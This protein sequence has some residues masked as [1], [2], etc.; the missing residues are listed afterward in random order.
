MVSNELDI[1][2]HWWITKALK[3][4]VSVLDG[5]TSFVFY[6]TSALEYF[7]QCLFFA[8]SHRS[9]LCVEEEILSKSILEWL[10]KV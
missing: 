5:A 2:G 1:N 4:N 9:Y 7:P 8:F 10:Q 6:V 3:L